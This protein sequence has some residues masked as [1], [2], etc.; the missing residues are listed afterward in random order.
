MKFA[1]QIKNLLAIMALC[2][3]GLAGPVWGAEVRGATGCV[4]CHDKDDL[5]DM[6]GTAHAEAPATKPPMVDAAAALAKR[7]CV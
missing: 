1:M 5:P 7:R 4:S 6:G 2:L 3:L